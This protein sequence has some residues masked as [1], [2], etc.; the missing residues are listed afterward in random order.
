MF[1]KVHNVPPGQLNRVVDEEETKRA[2]LD[3]FQACASQSGL[4]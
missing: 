1:D 2:A 3:T 4:N